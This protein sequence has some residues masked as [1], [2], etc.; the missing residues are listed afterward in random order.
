MANAFAEPLG[1]RRHVAAVAR[2]DL[3]ELQRGLGSREPGPD[4]R[5]PLAI[6]D[7]GERPEDLAKVTGTRADGAEDYLGFEILVCVVEQG[8][9]QCWMVRHNHIILPSSCV[10]PDPQGVE[11]MA[12]R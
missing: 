7:G 8:P 9:R 1:G 10:E 3:R 5:L 4:P 11:R 12:A 2:R 6:L